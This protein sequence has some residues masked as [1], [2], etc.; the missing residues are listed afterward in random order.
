MEK[1]NI[2]IFIGQF[3]IILGETD[4]A[5]KVWKFLVDSIADENIKSYWKNQVSSDCLKGVNL[6]RTLPMAFDS[7]LI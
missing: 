4:G 1:S 2:W 7:V 6:H 5:L 3:L